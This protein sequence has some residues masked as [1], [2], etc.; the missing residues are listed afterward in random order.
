MSS[1]AH[2]SGC[3]HLLLTN[4][5]VNSFNN[6]VFQSS[7]RDKTIVRAIDLVIGD[8]K[9]D[10][11]EKFTKR[12]PNDPTK[13]MGL[14]S[15][16]PIV[17]GEKYD[18]TS[19]INTVDGLTNGAECTVMKIDYRVSSS[20]RPSIIW[21]TF[22][23]ERIG[24]L[25]RS[26]YRSLRTAETDSLWTPILEVTKQFVINR[27]SN[28]K[29]RRRQFPL[30]QSAAKTVH[31]CQGDTL[32]ELIVSF[33]S[34]PRDH[35]HYVGLSRVVN[36]NSLYIE[37]LNEQKIT[38]SK[39]ATSE[40][41]RLREFSKYTP[42]VPF[43]RNFS[44][45]LKILFHNVRSFPLHKDDILHDF[46][47]NSADMNLF[48]E[49]NFSRRHTY[50]EFDIPGFRQHRN[51]HVCTNSKSIY[52]TAVCVISGLDPSVKVLPQNRNKI[53]ITV[54]VLSEPVNN[55]HVIILYRSPSKVS[56]RIL[57]ETLQLIH[58]DIAQNQPTVIIGDFNV[59]I[60][61]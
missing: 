4:A 57:L 8:V 37:T 18:L 26:E 17:V 5:M 29:F 6:S 51:S 50:E 15:N 35:I 44:T 13:T 46:N 59:D 1:A 2:I 49:T 43:I 58:H 27:T 45:S 60:L 41:K 21:V 23:E 33:A 14:H 11:K 39:K 56:F 54:A 20:N 28:F 42:S 30:R 10:V 53:E 40:M 38:V 24:F 22:T 16:L 31:R 3:T 32:K 19:N 25:Q 61:D 34:K 7:S 48:V 55:L 9:D 47:V 36:I 52:G 12:I